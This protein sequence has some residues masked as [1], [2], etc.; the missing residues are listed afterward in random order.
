MRVS[1]CQATSQ[2]V[3]V[4]ASVAA[5]GYQNFAA[6]GHRSA[7]SFRPLVHDQPE[8]IA[9]SDRDFPRVRHAHSM[10]FRDTCVREACVD[11]SGTW[12]EAGTHL[13]M[14]PLT[15]YSARGRCVYLSRRYLRLG[16]HVHVR[17]GVLFCSTRRNVL[18]DGTDFQEGEAN[19]A[20]FRGVRLGICGAPEG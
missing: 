18:A 6:P 7:G 10:E 4:A 1:R 3:P 15:S 14:G 5:P 16:S 20:A 11:G 2:E 17:T 19:A 13:A 8:A 12:G 9:V